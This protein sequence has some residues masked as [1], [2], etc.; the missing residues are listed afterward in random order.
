[1]QRKKQG[2]DKALAFIYYKLTMHKPAVSKIRI[3]LL[4]LLTAEDRFTNPKKCKEKSQWKQ[5]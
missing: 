4:Q 3:H 1:M 5:N 2:G